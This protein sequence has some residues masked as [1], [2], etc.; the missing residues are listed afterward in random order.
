MVKATSMDS[1][2]NLTVSSNWEWKDYS[3][4]EKRDREPFDGAYT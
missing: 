1:A 3:L 2:D 4:P